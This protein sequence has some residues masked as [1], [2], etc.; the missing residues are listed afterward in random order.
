MVDRNDRHSYS[1]DLDDS[2]GLVSLSI[3]SPM[4][5]QL[6]PRSYRLANA[7]CQVYLTICQIDYLYAMA[8]LHGPA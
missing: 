4:A 7:K 2:L 3:W 5:F 6:Q 8:A 1:F